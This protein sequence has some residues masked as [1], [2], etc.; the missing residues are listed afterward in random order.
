MIASLSKSEINAGL[1]KSWIYGYDVIV[2]D[3]DII[4]S[5]YAVFSGLCSY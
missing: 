2:V 1:G 4:D 5:N 3:T